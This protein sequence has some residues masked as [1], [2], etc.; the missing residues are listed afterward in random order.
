MLVVVRLAPARRRTFCAG[1]RI[2]APRASLRD[3]GRQGRIIGRIS[4]ALTAESPIPSVLG[5]LRLGREHAINASGISDD[6]PW[7]IYI[8]VGFRRRGDDR[9]QC[10]S[11]SYQFFHVGTLPCELANEAQP[12]SLTAE[13]SIQQETGLVFNEL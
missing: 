5:A 2:Y 12:S 1:S 3:D 13:R 9:G 7:I 6:A 8:R 10:Q 4:D 11:G